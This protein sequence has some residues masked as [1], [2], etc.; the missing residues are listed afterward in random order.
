M[1]PLMPPVLC[2]STPRYL[3]F[4]DL[5]SCL[6]LI[7]QLEPV[8]ALLVLANTT[9]SHFFGF[10]CRPCASQYATKQSISVCS[11]LGVLAH[12]V[13]SS[14][15]SM[16]VTSMLSSVLGSCTRTPAPLA[17]STRYLCRSQMYRLNRVVLSGHPCL[18]PVPTEKAA[19]S[20]LS[21]LTMH[22]VL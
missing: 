13:E 14:A 2:S 11:C 7:S 10:T 4:W 16:S 15:Y 6:P 20:P 17:F 3:N 9:T 22:A 21:H 5:G 19:A 8:Q 18:R 1:Q 12:K